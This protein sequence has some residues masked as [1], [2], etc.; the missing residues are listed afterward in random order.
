MLKSFNMKYAG[1]FR[2]MCA[3]NYQHRT[4]FDRVI[5]KI[6][7][8]QFICLTGYVIT[9]QFIRSNAKQTPINGSIKYNENS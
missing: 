3:K 5:E 6:K 9:N 4:W 8:V 7:R 1:D 2:Y